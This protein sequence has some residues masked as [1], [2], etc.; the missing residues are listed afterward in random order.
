MAAAVISTPGR[1]R[2]YTAAD[3][4]ACYGKKSSDPGDTFTP[5]AT[6][7]AS[8]AANAGKLEAL[9]Y[10]ADPQT[11][12]ADGKKITVNGFN[13]HWDGDAWAAGAAPAS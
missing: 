2:N 1:L 13:F 8:D 3:F 12:W 6:V 4:E 11:P 7:T 9:G 5:E 10:V